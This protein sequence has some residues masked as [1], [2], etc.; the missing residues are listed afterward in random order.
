MSE[1]WYNSIAMNIKKLVKPGVYSLK[2]YQAKEIPCKIKLD[3]NESPY[4]FRD[5]YNVLRSIKTNRY[6]DPEAKNLRKIIAK[7][8]SVKPEN[9]LQGNGSDELIYYLIATFGGPVLFPEPTFSM[10]GIIATALDEKTLPVALDGTFDLDIEKIFNHLKKE[11]PKLIFLSSPNNPTGNCFSSEKILKIIEKTTQKSI[12]IIDEAYQPFSS[13]KGYIPL[14]NDYENLV[15]MRTLSKI[16]MAALRTGFLI[17]SEEIIEQVNKVRLPF[18]LN[19]FSQKIACE[20][21]KKKE[22]LGKYIKSICNERDR[23]FKEM[24]KIKGV[25]AYPSE[26]NFILF[27]VENSEMVYKSLLKAGVLIRNM[28]SVVNDCLRVTI[29]TIKE[30]NI[31]LEELRKSI[32]NTRN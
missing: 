21:L 20:I 18:N 4:G 2:A 22:L 25:I 29:G 6:P 31:F 12:V 30:N 3:A 13:K 23:L 5:F 8:F 16:G 26:A 32:L 9:I 17:A 7:E 14:L 15:I 10:Y 19:S 24:S 1:I 28:N 27:K 11:N